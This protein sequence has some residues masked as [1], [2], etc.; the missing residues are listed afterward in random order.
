MELALDANRAL[1]QEQSGEGDV[2]REPLKIA[3]G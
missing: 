1:A 3:A 2:I